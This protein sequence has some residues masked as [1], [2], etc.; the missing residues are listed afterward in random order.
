MGKIVNQVELAEI[1]GKDPSTIWEWQEQGLPIKK[2][3]VGRAGSEYDTAEVYAWL[4]KRE[5]ERAGR[6]EKP[7]EREA[8]LRGDMLELE[9]AKERGSLVPADQVAPIWDGRV[10]AAGF[11][12]A[13][14]ASRLAGLLEAAS[15]IEAKRAIL[16]QEDA[17]FLTHL[18]S[19]GPAIQASVDEVL[20]RL[21]AEDAAALLRRLSS[22]G[23]QQRDGG[24]TA[25]D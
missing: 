19:N 2:Q 21:V 15:G 6:G 17:E 5:L 16:K 4:V 7:S 20:E 12:L 25:A 13:A 23:D 14:R 9:I 10:L 24:A 11:A 18:G 8:R 3:G 1:L 22:H